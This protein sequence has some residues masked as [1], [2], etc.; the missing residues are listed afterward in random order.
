MTIIEIKTINTIKEKYDAR[1]ALWYEDHV[2]K[3]DPNAD[4]KL[5]LILLEFLQL[6]IFVKKN[7]SN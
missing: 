4:K 1:I 3:N 5:K 6:S 7:Q 2:T